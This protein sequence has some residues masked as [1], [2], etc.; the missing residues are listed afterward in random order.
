MVDTPDFSITIAD[1]TLNVQQ[2]KSKN[3]TITI[4][5]VNKF[6]GTVSL[7]AILPKGT[8]LTVEISPTLV[9]ILPNGSE[10]MVLTVNVPSKIDKREYKFT[11]KGTSNKLNHTMD[12]TVNVTR[13]SDQD[14]QNW[15]VGGTAATAVAL[16]IAFALIYA[17][18]NSKWQIAAILIGAL[19]GLTHEIAQSQ[20]KFALPNWDK[21]NNYCLGSLFGFIE[22]I[23]AALVIL[24]AQT[25]SAPAFPLFYVT[26]F[27]AGLGL[28]GV[29]DAI[30]P[31]S[32]PS[33]KKTNT[34]SSQ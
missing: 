18:D 10:Q 28:K 13:F 21:N 34:Q 11:L 25:S 30:Q 14:K 33:T 31:S 7:E 27:L 20:G 9:D 32:G 22:G 8:Q 1:A 23:I 5:S 19:G 16:I 17:Y 15:S 26:S 4:A 2:G 12:V 24:S 3:T 6:D 29:S